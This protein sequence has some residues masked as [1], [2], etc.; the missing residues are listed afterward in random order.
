MRA[1]IF[2]RFVRGDGDRSGARGGSGLGLSIVRAVAESLGGSVE[3]SE[4][5]A[6]GARF[7]VR[8]PAAAAAE[9]EAERVSSAPAALSGGS[10]S[11]ER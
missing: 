4:N 10:A 1:Q 6:G 8:I 11:E 5:E 3:L 9:P 2:D 7:V